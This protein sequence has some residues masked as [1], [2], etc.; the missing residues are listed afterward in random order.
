MFFVFRRGL[1][2]GPLVKELSRTGVLWPNGKEISL[3]PRK[4]H[5]WG[6]GRRPQKRAFLNEGRFISKRVFC[7]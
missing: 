4:P 5:V 1:C 7:K 6:L 2:A 3:S